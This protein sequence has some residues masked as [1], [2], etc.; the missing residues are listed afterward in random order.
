MTRFPFDTI[1]FDLDGTLVD[2]NLD[3]APAVNHALR[4]EGREEIPQDKIR[5]FIGGGGMGMLSKALE[6]SGGMVSE[7]RFDELVDILLE[8]Y[9]AHIADNTV[10]FGGVRGALGALQAR[11]VKLAVCTN[12]S[13]GPARDLIEKLGMTS[14]FSA[15][16]GADTLGR[17]RAKPHPDMLLAAAKD[18][19]GERFAMVGDSSYDTRAAKAAGCPVVLVTFGYNDV[20]LDSIE[21]DIRIDHFDELVTSLEALGS[22]AN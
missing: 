9:W 20:P 3:L 21:A 16:Y 11:G 6:W 8:H 2:S 10:P 19:G 7:D 1:L 18:C 17:E 15:I 14:Y 12:K 4:I 13:E 5:N 22:A